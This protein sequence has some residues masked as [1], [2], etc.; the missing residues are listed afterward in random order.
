MDDAQ[1]FKAFFTH[2]T[3][4]ELTGEQ[5]AAF[6]Q[7]V[8]ELRRREREGNSEALAKATMQTAAAV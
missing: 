2:V 8:D 4:A 6:V 5:E 1:L 7:I 3:G